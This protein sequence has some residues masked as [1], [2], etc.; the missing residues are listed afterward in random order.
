M[1]IS[2]FSAALAARLPHSS[3][4]RPR[5]RR[6]PQIQNRIPDRRPQSAAPSV[7]P[8]YPQRQILQR[9][10]R[11]I[12]AATQ[13]RIT[14]IP[15]PRNSSIGSSNEH[16]PKLIA[17]SRRAAAICSALRFDPSHARVR[18]RTGTPR[19]SSVSTIPASPRHATPAPPPETHSQ[20]HASS[21]ARFRLIGKL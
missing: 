16:D 20:T 2:A 15:A 17:N 1:A 10:I 21:L 18:L 7:Q 3:A 9:K 13:L 19:A 11:P 8:E 12:R 5:L 6:R 14:A 4:S